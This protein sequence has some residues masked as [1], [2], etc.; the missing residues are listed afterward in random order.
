MGAKVFNHLPTKAKS[1]PNDL[2]NFKLQLTTFLTQSSF[3]T[4]DEFFR[5]KY[6]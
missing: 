3:Y 2:K 4:N 6:A 1:M 5:T